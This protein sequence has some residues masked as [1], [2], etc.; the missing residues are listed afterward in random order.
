MKKAI[1]WISIIGVSLVVLVIAALV[2]IPMFVDLQKY[3]PRIETEVAEATGRTFRLGGDFNLSLFPWASLSFSDLH[4]GNPS[5]FEEK[6]FVSIES[7]DV[8]VKL[9]PLLFKDIQVK[10][11]ILKGTRIV[12][13]TT[14]DGRISWEFGKKSMDDVSASKTKKKVDAKPSEGLSLKALAVGEFSITDGAVVWLDQTKKERKEIS[15][16]SLVL[17]DISLDRPVQLKFS[18]RLDNRPFSLAGSVGPLGK[19]FGKGTIPLDLLVKALDQLD[20]SLKGYVTDPAMQP[21]F[22][23]DVQVSPFSPRKL[24]AGLGMAFPISTADPKALN[25]IALKATVK[26]DTQAVSVSNGV[27]DLDES[28]LNFTAKAGDFS[29]PDITFDF[30]LNH[31]DL[32]KYMPP[33]SEET[34]AKKDEKISESKPSQKKI[35]YAPLRRLVLNGALQIGKLKIKNARIENTRV[36]IVGKKGVFNIDPLAMALYQGDVS[37]KA[38][39]NVQKDT[40]VSNFRLTAKGIQSGPLLIDVLNK[41]IIEGGLKA[42]LNLNMT[43]DDA[44]KIKKSLNGD[45]D[46]L[47]NDGAIKGIDLAG[48]VRNV[49]ATFGL[50]EAGEKK[51]RTDFAELNVPFT[52][53]GGIVNTTNTSLTSPLIRVTTAGKADLVGENLDFRVEPKFVA[54]IKG[55]GDSKDRSGLTVPVLV[56]GTF[57]SPKFRPDLEGMFKQKIEQA[58]PDLKKK[59]LEGGTGKGE[60]KPVEKKVKELFKG[61]GSGS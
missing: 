5:G 46:F 51:P 49:K 45:G 11:F 21:R 24:V 22:D 53:S 17:Q 61:F 42:N 7:F 18:A 57:S 59:L 12:L 33:P 10:R 40:P 36:K 25:Q 60:S 3:K 16:V 27:L 38:S 43:G 39:L 9:L 58:L 28:Q 15:D 29:K 23:L 13:E 41:D 50:A 1:K 34:P 6:D 32:D 30:N 14:K 52:I 19:E 47:F 8:R 37:A 26:G 55:Q 20:V 44:G 4:L 31:I 56:T 35:D 54:T 48:M 2:L